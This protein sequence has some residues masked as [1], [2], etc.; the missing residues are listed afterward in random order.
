MSEE[1]KNEIKDLNII[2]LELQE[3]LNW[4]REYAHYISEN[5]YTVDAEAATYADGDE[6]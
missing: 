2:I 1:I 5:H 6:D 4:F 3:E